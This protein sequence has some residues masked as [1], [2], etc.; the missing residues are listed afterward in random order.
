[1][2]TEISN[3][4]LF[5]ASFLRHGKAFGLSG[6]ISAQT[7]AHTIAIAKKFAADDRLLGKYTGIA[8]RNAAFAHAKRS[9]CTFDHE[10][11]N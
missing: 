2:E 4:A 1:M 10:I 6:I 5:L 8:I 9:T 7:I 3:L 11:K